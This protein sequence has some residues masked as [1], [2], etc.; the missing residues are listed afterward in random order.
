MRRAGRFAPSGSL[1]S[2]GEESVSAGASRPPPT[3]AQIPTARV[4]TTSRPQPVH[5]L[6][7]VDVARSRFAFVPMIGYTDR[8]TVPSPFRLR[9]EQ[10]SCPAGDASARV[11][12]CGVHATR[13]HGPREPGQA[14]PPVSPHCPHAYLARRRIQTNPPVA[15]SKR[16]QHVRKSRR[17]RRAE[18]SKRT[19]GPRKCWGIGPVQRERTR[20]VRAARH[21]RRSRP[22]RDAPPD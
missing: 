16:T 5:A 15:K 12:A 2:H 17:A 3:R 18:N 9:K 22:G 20:R 14:A 21:D 19:R 10:P 7:L 8:A 1:S 4:L 13:S 11:G 6:L